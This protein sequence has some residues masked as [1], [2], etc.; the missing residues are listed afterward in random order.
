MGKWLRYLLGC[1]LLLLISASAP[2]PAL[3][4]PTKIK[5]A[6][7]TPEGSTWVKVLKE[8]AADIKSRTAGDVDFIIYAGG[9]SGDEVDVLRKMRVN[10]IQAAGFS[11]V[12]LGVVLPEVRVLE[13]PL[14][15]QNDKEIDTVREQMFD[16]FAQ[17]LLKKGFIL[18][19]FTE[20][21]WVYLFSQKDLSKPATFKSAKMWVWK[22]DRVAETFLHNFGIRTTPLH[23]AE[24]N[25]GL[26]RRMIDSFYSPAMAAVAFQWHARAR[27]VLDF[28]MANSTAALVM[29]KRAF[30][31]LP[32]GHQTIIKTSARAHCR[33]LVKLTRD[34]NRKALEVMKAQGISFVT[35]TGDQLKTFQADARKTY[36]QSIPRLYSRTLFERI[37]AILDTLRDSARLK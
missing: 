6:V 28:P 9:V 27:Y 12:G 7:V 15:F 20:G 14:L 25:T 29:T 24:V 26:E 32:P 8:M 1:G 30:A 3:A 16:Y 23:I 35:P 31:S 18:L 22:G 36:H 19:G 17:A 34:D 5:A 2:P 4:G 13:A 10:R 33:K 11:G 37:Q 21:G